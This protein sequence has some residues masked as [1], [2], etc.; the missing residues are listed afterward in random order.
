MLDEPNTVKVEKVELLQGVTQVF[1]IAAQAART[2]ELSKT[3]FHYIAL[4]QEHK[5]GLPL[6]LINYL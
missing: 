3:T 2:T 6:W 5:P 4:E 1:V